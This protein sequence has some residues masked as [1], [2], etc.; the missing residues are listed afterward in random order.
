MLTLIGIIVF[1]FIVKAIANYCDE[2]HIDLP[3]SDTPYTPDLW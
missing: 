1:Y 3:N 2:H